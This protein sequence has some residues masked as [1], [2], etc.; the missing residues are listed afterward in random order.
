MARAWQQLSSSQ[1]HAEILGVDAARST[2]LRG[3]RPQSRRPQTRGHNKIRGRLWTVFE[4]LRFHLPRTLSGFLPSPILRRVGGANRSI[5]RGR[6]GRCVG[7]ELKT[8]FSRSLSSIHKLC[9]HTPAAPLRPHPEQCC[10]LIIFHWTKVVHYP[11][12][13]NRQYTLITGEL[14]ST[15]S[16]AG[17]IQ[18]VDELPA[19][20]QV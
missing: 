8:A 17:F 14:C 4:W 7:F 1:E 12:V 18:M 19:F 11:P 5:L 3:R 10:G 20:P 6:S 13:H 2:Q 15:R 16:L 9:N